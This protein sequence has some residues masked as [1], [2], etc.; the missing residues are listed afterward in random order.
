VFF[1]DIEP[2]AVP[3]LLAGR[4]IAIA[5]DA[6][7]GFAYPAN[8]ETL[9]ELGAELRPFSPLAGDPL[10]DCDAVWLPGG[11]PELHAAALAANRALWAALAAHVDAGKP[12]LAECGGMMSL[13]ETIVDKSGQA[14][15]LA[16][17]LPG[18]AMMQSRLT[19]L[20]TQFADLP[21]GTLS[22]HTFHYS[23]TETSLVPLTRARKQNG[24]E[25]EAIYRRGRL[26]ASYVHFYF[27]SSP[28]A[29]A[30]LFQ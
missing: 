28:A 11:Y 15:P 16:G 13:F 1:P 4:R 5:R 24:D 2:P 29:T 6:A 8:L 3:S 27:P 21:E 20:G 30:A 26:T 10:P 12:V 17:L 19:A 14:H 23:R 22:G 25:G 18:R 9:T 7:Y